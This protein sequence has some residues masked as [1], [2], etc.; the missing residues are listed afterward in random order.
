MKKLIMKM[1]KVKN[2]KEYQ[3]NEQITGEQRKRLLRLLED[4]KDIFVKDKNEL[5]KC[6]I[7]KHRIDTGDA[8]PIKQEKYRASGKE[9]KLIEEEIKKML[10]KGV[11]K[12][13]MSPWASPI[14]LV[15]KKNGERRFCID[16]RKVNKVTKRD[17]HPLPRIDEDRKS[18]R[19]NSSH[20]AL[21]RMP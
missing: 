21:S 18:T 11:I 15:P 3:I 6:E 14:V 20:V 5:G 13:S 10:E 1:K 12:K 7:V 2:K 4:Y 16:L 19:L 8:K 9:R 17:E